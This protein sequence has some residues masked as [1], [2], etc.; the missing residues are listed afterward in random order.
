MWLQEL[1]TNTIPGTL[2]PKARFI[3]VY[4][5]FLALFSHTFFNHCSPIVLSCGSA[6]YNADFCSVDWRTVWVEHSRAHEPCY[7]SIVARWSKQPVIHPFSW[8]R[9][10]Q[11]LIIHLWTPTPLECCSSNSQLSLGLQR[12]HKSRKLQRNRLHKESSY[13]LIY[14]LKGWPL[15]FPCPF[16]R[17][18]V[19]LSKPHT[20]WIH[21]KHRV[22]SQSSSQD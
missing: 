22:Q 14:L 21:V 1:D 11:Q 6:S 19:S 7:R 18:V 20:K 2:T 3:F 15:E 9:I 16:T 13:I 10:V 12:P 17:A 4:R 5:C 8:A